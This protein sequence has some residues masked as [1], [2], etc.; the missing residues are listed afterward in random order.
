MALVAAVA[1]ATAAASACTDPVTAEKP[2][3]ALL[4]HYPSQSSCRVQAP[5]SDGER[6]YVPFSDGYVRAFALASGVLQ[7]QTMLG[8]SYSD[9]I[10]VYDGRV[11]L[12]ADTRVA[13]LDPLRGGTLW[14]A[15]DNSD[16]LRG[17][18]S[19]DTLTAAVIAGGQFRF[20]RALNIADGSLAWKIDLGESVLSTVVVDRTVYVGTIDAAA[21]PADAVG[22]IVA[23]DLDSRT[24]RWSFYA[25]KL[26]VRS[27]FVAPLAV[28]DGIIVG[29]AASG[30]VYGVDASTGREIWHFDG[31][32]F[33]GGSVSDGHLVYVPSN[34]SHLYALDLRSG[35]QVWAAYFDG[36]SLYTEP[37]LYADSLVVVK[38]GAT[39]YALRRSTGDRAWTYHLGNANICSTPL[40]VGT[41]IIVDA[42]D[43]IYALEPAR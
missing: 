8:G 21:G 17:V 9:D 33:L 31:N 25:P 7:W 12:Q 22:H 24:R 35:A 14:T 11:V 16:F 18:L 36:P 1:A 38:V 43:G 10:E 28:S 13:A 3:L 15:S 6:V 5:A 41:R 37:A 27:G 20:L 23:I 4:W 34:D 32:T 2:A 30:R 29:T 39:L 42:E 26:Q 40:V 19:F